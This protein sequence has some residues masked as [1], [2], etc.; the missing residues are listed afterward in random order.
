MGFFEFMEHQ[1]RR[2][3]SS[4]SNSTS[5][6]CSSSQRTLRKKFPL[7]GFV[8]VVDQDEGPSIDIRQD[9][10]IGDLPVIV[11]IIRALIRVELV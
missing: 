2:I 4:T 6:P 10:L 8:S 1:Q 11:F 3:S 5:E 7:H 9:V